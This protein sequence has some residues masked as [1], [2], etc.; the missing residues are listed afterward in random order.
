MAKTM[1]HVLAVS[2]PSRPGYDPA[3]PYYDVTADS[4]S[5]FFVGPVAGDHKSGD[6]LRAEAIAAIDN[7]TGPPGGLLD[8]LLGPVKNTFT[9]AVY[10]AK[11]EASRQQLTGNVELR[12]PGEPPRTM[13]ENAS[14]EQMVEVISSNADSSTVAVTS[15]EWVRLGNDLSDHQDSFGK[16]INNSLGNWEG[17]SG[18]AARRHLAQ[19]ATWLGSTA[20]GAV[21]TGRQ[22]EIHSQALSETQRVMADN[23]PVPFSAPEANARLAQITDPAQFA[24]QFQTELDTFNQ[25]QAAR[26]QAAAVMQRFDETVGGAATTPKFTAP[27]SLL[28]A[29]RATAPLQGTT[30]DTL[31]V[32]RD[33]SVGTPANEEVLMRQNMPASTT[34]ANTGTLP[35]SLPAANLPGGVTGQGTPALPSAPAAYSPA[36]FTTPTGVT[37]PSGVVTPGAF[38]PPNAQQLPHAPTVPSGYGGGNPPG[39][40]TTP[41]TFTKPTI[42]T[43]PFGEAEPT[44]RLL[45]KN[46]PA[47][48]NP[49]TPNLPVMPGRGPGVPPVTGGLPGGG[50]G[51][52]VGRFGP[53]SMPGGGPGGVPG[54]GG[55]G[56]GAAGRGGFGPMGGAGAGAGAGGAASGVAGGAQGGPGAPGGGAGGARGLGSGGS[57]MGGGGAPGGK[58]RGEDDDEYQGASYLE[59]DAEIFAP[60]EVVSPPV[61]GDWHGQQ[62]WK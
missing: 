30:A 11:L 21:L 55:P 47:S 61:I 19:V 23:P 49:N 57:P 22:Q 35:N 43:S 15:E 12:A 42:P 37:G 20:D 33:A 38:T 13:W 28:R 60:G 8:L 16:A 51:P 40:I 3:S 52:G 17:T 48:S 4:S 45:P 36:A 50:N 5:T 54:G 29:T 24:M 25:Q 2:D 62:D 46:R 59:G 44:T 32:R 31:A 14:H 34:P 39:N 6:E 26:G 10:Q 27:P 1:D 7:V 18:D 58:S 56:A 9:Q 41:S 53:G